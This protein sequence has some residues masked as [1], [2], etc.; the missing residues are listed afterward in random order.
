MSAGTISI[1]NNAA[2]VAG[3]GTAF[4]A[5]LAAGDFIVITTGGVTYTLP[6]K[7]IERDT[8]LTLT[9]NYSGPA[10]TGA[11]WTAMPRDTLNRI[12]GQIA[13]DTAYAIRQRVL[14]IDN[15]YQLLEVNGD[16][17]IKMADG[18]SYTGPSWLKLIDVMKELQIDELIPIAEQIRADAKQ[19]AEDK[20][21]IV[22]AKE[23]AEAAAAAAAVSEG[24]AVT[25]ESNAAESASTASTKANEAAESAKQAAASNPQ[26]ALQKSLNLQDLADRAAAWLN[27]RPV[28]STPLAAAAVNDGD[29][30][31]WLQVQNLVSAGTGGP[32]M[33][34]VMNYHVGEAVQ[35]ETRAYYP[36]NCL[37]R[38]GQIVNR[39][40]WPELWAWAQKT[41][42]IT[43]AAWLADVTKRGSYSTGDG[44][45]TF[46]LPDW[47]GVQSGSIPGVFFGGG[48][49][50]NDKLLALN[51]APDFG[52]SFGSDMAGV[53]WLAATSASGGF[54]V[55]AYQTNNIF[56]PTSGFD[57]YSGYGLWEFKGSYSNAAYGRNNATEVAPNR[58]Y[59]VWLVRAS[60]G[61]VAA[62][63]T[64]DVVN[65]LTAAPGVSTTN[66]GGVV[67]STLKVGT[68]DYGKAGLRTV[69][70]NS[71]TGVKTV[72]AEVLVSDSTGS[73][74][75]TKVIK[76]GTV[77]GLTG[78][79]VT[80]PIG[81]SGISNASYDSL[82]NNNRNLG[83]WS[84]QMNAPG[85]GYLY[86]HISLKLFTPGV[87]A[88]VFTWSGLTNTG[89]PQ[90]VL[91]YT[92]EANTTPCMWRFDSATGNGIAANGSW[93]NGASD[94]RAKYE[95]E[96]LKDA[97][98]ALDGIKARTWRMNT[99][100]GKG[101]FGIGV[102]ANGLYDQF[103]EATL[104]AGD[105]EMDD[106]TT[107]KDALTVQAGDS[108]VTVAVLTAVMQDMVKRMADLEAKLK[109]LTE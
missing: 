37:P 98:G 30:P 81:R 67:N 36:P 108:G 12:S 79:A 89:G 41:S 94:E 50:T 86:P 51:A 14:E 76:L 1:Q 75:T 106:G 70:T 92:T 99:K 13:A 66:Y 7:S 6:I 29:A 44:S 58:V 26:L 105:L 57:K 47:N 62:N 20:P 60:G 65:A 83:H 53:A 101:R 80:S 68:A 82:Y 28:G 34:G 91:S 93:V 52:G 18:S 95:I 23:D 5:E 39:A 72:S 59:G 42:P 9:R 64:W 40:D 69:V 33:N 25:S 103:P 21:V 109:A 84:E 97:Y 19:V 90:Y 22:Q 107:L 71:S 55:T 16:V 56:H 45:T 77:D 87:N 24:N 35:W 31:Q 17:T 85:T 102:L 48:A 2:A 74:T 4:T 78:G 27:V 61:F 49:G 32:T 96:E 15:W 104:Y 43:D 100:A 3:D 63:T 11:A 10:V 46:R 73:T 88:G 38:D 54:K 8:A